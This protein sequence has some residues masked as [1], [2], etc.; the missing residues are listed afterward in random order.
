MTLTRAHFVFRLQSS[1]LA[2]SLGAAGKKKGDKGK[3]KVPEPTLST[4]INFKDLPIS[5]STIKGLHD[6]SFTEM[7]L[8]QRAAIPHALA[9]RDILGAAKT[10]SGKTLSFLV[11]LVEL[12]YRNKWGAADGLGAIVLSPTRELALQSFDV[13]RKVGRNHSLSAGLIIGGKDFSEEQTRIVKMNIL[14]ATPG[15]LLQ[16]M[17]ET[18]GFTCDGVQ[19]LVLDE[20]DRILD[21]GFKVPSLPAAPVCR[22]ADKPSMGRSPEPPCATGLS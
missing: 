1:T 17:D 16:H 18:P 11:P 10:G 15:R 5:S 21:M 2:S 7:T 8:I 4:A 22:G 3:S 6:A 19:M 9:G 20:A 14:I 13:L 12:L